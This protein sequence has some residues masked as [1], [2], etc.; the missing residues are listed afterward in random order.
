MGIGFVIIAVNLT[1]A[2]VAGMTPLC[3][4]DAEEAEDGVQGFGP[5]AADLQQGDTRKGGHHLSLWRH[6]QDR[7]QPDGGLQGPSA[8]H[9]F[10]TL[11]ITIPHSQLQLPLKLSN[12]LEHLAYHGELRHILTEAGKMKALRQI[13]PCIARATLSIHPTQQLVCDQS[14]LELQ[15]VLESVIFVHQEE[16]NWPLSEATVLKKKFDDIFAA[17]KYTKVPPCS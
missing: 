5:G 7:A 6:G 3:A 9:D 13:S 17:T 11:V 16:S 4:A 14:C 15:A 12:Y 8:L 2:R 1:A 10:Q